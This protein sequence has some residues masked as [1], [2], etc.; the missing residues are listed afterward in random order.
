MKI[1]NRLNR[2]QRQI[3]QNRRIYSSGVAYN[4]GTTG[5]DD[6][7]NLTAASSPYY[8]PDC[9]AN[10]FTCSS[11]FSSGSSSNYSSD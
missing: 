5:V 2:S 1:F 8:E 7:I 3:Q 9:P 6:F 10:D 4:S 11:D